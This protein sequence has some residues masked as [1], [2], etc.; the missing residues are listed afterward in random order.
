MNQ[1]A[2]AATK[3]DNFKLRF[4]EEL[5]QAGAD[6]EKLDS[7][8]WDDAAPHFITALHL[9][10]FVARRELDMLEALAVAGEQDAAIAVWKSLSAER[11]ELLL[12]YMD[13]FLDTVSAA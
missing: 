2:L 6:A 3:F 10:V 7:L 1:W 11:R 12:R 5:L 8:T 4:R 9:K 13:F